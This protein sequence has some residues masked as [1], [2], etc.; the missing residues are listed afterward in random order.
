MISTLATCTHPCEHIGGESSTRSPP[1]CSRGLFLGPATARESLLTKCNHQNRYIRDPPPKYSKIESLPE[2][3][4]GACFC[5]C[6]G[7]SLASGPS[8]P[9]RGFE[10]PA[11]FWGFALDGGCHTHPP[12]P[13]HP[14]QRTRRGI[15]RARRP[16]QDPTPK[17]KTWFQPSRAGLR[18][19]RARRGIQRARRLLKDPTPKP[20]A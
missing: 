14:F 2:T 19:A 9:F 5:A 10:P 18:T 6:P 15:Q 11:F 4:P 7:P 13:P 16:L 20:K 17:P 3:F 8:G 1:T 12:A